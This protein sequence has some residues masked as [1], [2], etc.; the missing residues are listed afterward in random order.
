MQ[1][2]VKTQ[3]PN[4]PTQIVCCWHPAIIMWWRWRDPHSSCHCT[5]LEFL[6][7]ASVMVSE[8]FLHKKITWGI[9]KTDMCQRNVYVDKKSIELIL[10]LGS[11][12]A[13][14]TELA[15]SITSKSNPMILQSSRMILALLMCNKPGKSISLDVRYLVTFM[16]TIAH[17]YVL[18]IQSSRSCERSSVHFNWLV[19]AH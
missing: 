14:L 12:E 6:Y 3:I 19:L 4:K 7:M 8:T 9:Q 11:K 1:L 15:L 17:F 10:Q 5:A 2:P 13:K 18:S 16:C